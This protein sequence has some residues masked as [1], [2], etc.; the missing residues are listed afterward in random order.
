MAQAPLAFPVY[1]AASISNAAANITGYYSPNT[2]ISVY[3]QD[4]A[5]FTS[6]TAWA[7]DGHIIG[8][9]G[10]GL[11]ALVNNQPASVYFQSP[12]QVNVLIP[13]FMV[14]GP[15]TVQ[16][17]NEGRAGPAVQI[18]LGDTAPALFPMQ[19]QFAIATHGNGPV[20]TSDY[21]ATRG[22]VVVIYAGG[23]GPTNPAQLPYDAAYQAAQVTRFKEFQVLLNNVPVDPSLIQYVGVTPG[24]AGLYQINL[25]LPANAP[26][27]PDVRI[28]YPERMSPS[29]RTLPLR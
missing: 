23:L 10:S 1:S 27:D 26:N 6:S 16:L 3:G 28:G 15:A 18:M 20:V 17:L 8:I 11:R 13:S 9:P 25:K 4:L 29:G 2:F 21:P 22:E 7:V 19:G 12:G 5:S 24:Y 14:S